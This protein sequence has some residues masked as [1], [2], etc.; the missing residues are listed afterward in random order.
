M[1]EIGQELERFFAIVVVQEIRNDQ[2]QPR[3]RIAGDEAR[4]RGQ[5][6]GLAAG[7]QSPRGNSLAG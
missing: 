3:L 1:A 4:G 6:I 2:Q 7:L 5:E